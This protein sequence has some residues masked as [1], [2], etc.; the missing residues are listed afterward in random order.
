MNRLLTDR[1][2]WIAAGLFAWA[3]EAASQQCPEQFVTL[4]SKMQALMDRAVRNNELPGMVA[5][6]TRP[7]CRP[8]MTVSGWRDFE[9]RI[10]MQDNCIFDIRSITKPITAMAALVLAGRGRLHLDEPIVGVFAGS[11]L[12]DWARRVTLR[13]L[14]THT[15][16]LG[17]ARPA[18]L[19]QLTEARDVPLSRVARMIL[20]M[21]LEGP[22]GIWRYS[23]P[24][25]ALIGRLIELA[26]QTSFASFV[27]HEVLRPLGMHDSS[28]LPPARKRNRL[29]QLYEWREHKLV[30]WPR[31]LPPDRWI[32]ESPDFGLYSTA[33]DLARLLDSVSSESFSLFSAD[34]KRS[35]FSPAAPT[36]WA[37]LSQGLGW[38]VAKNNEAQRQ[39]GIKQNCFG[40]NGAG[41]SM[42]W[43]DPVT[44]ANVLFLTQ[45]F[46][47]HSTAGPGVVRLAFTS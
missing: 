19:E 25:F 15:S 8:I 44:G 35:M 10:P 7:H 45:C 42:A 46:A 31:R 41:G 17:Q 3:R 23:S 20:D 12:P 16:G 13:N 5:L 29:T 37:G 22:T 6:I 40:H 38:M 4:Q 47:T 43:R 24:G 14:L 26:A 28:F 33:L 11:H 21:P 9:R 30:S 18:G 2:N 36:E 1:R 27:T 39:L 32:Y 34:L